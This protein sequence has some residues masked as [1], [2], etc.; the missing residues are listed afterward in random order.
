MTGQFINK[1]VAFTFAVFLLFLITNTAIAFHHHPLD[2]QAHDDCPIC[3]TAHV[4]SFAEFDF[5]APV[6]QCPGITV[7]D[8]IPREY[9]SFF[10][11]LLLTHHYKRAPPF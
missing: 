3:A 4:T 6:I 11:P 10:E 7:S 2:D 9:E 1:R 5:S 8:L